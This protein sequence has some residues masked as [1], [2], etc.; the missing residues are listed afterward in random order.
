MAGFNVG[1]KSCNEVVAIIEEA[2]LQAN[3]FFKGWR[4]ISGRG[5][6]EDSQT[7]LHPRIEPAQESRDV[8]ERQELLRNRD[9]LMAL[10]G[11]Q[12]EIFHDP[13]FLRLQLS[14]EMPLRLKC[15]VLLVTEIIPRDSR[16]ASV[17]F[18]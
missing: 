17:R 1:P 5:F 6:M 11:G 10:G 15:R 12:D 8:G 13:D 9:G 7:L 18:P 4:P 2:L 14:T 16:Y 3:P